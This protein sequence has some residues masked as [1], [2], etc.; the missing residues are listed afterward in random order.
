M[1]LRAGRV[2]LGLINAELTDIEAPFDMRLPADITS[3]GPIEVDPIVA[4][5]RCQELRIEIP[6]I[7][8]MAIGSRPLVW[9]AVWRWPSL[10]CHRQVRAL[11]PHV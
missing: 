2:A 9:R 5:A 6:R 10:G 7:D 11:F 1:P 8:N 4:L 3:C